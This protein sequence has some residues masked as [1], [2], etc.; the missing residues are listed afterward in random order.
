MKEKGV[1]RI[2]EVKDWRGEHMWYNIQRYRRPWWAFKKRWMTERDNQ[3]FIL[4][5]HNLVDCQ[6]YINRGGNFQ[7]SYRLV[8]PEEEFTTVIEE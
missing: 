7:H 5:L 8:I 2:F 1:Y 4:H 3:G 6:T